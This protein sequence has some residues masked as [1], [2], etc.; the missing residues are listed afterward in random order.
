[1]RSTNASGSVADG[2]YAASWDT[3][4]YK[5]VPKLHV[6]ILSSSVWMS[7]AVLRLWLCMASLHPVSFAIFIECW[8]DVPVS[9]LYSQPNL[10]SHCT[11]CSWQISPEQ[12]QL[13]AQ[14]DA[15]SW[16]A[17]VCLLTYIERMMLIVGIRVLV[18]HKQYNKCMMHVWS[19][20]WEHC[21]CCSGCVLHTGDSTCQMEWSGCT[22]M[23]SACLIY[24]NFTIL[25]LDTLQQ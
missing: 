12:W 19:W 1:M 22:F 14:I 24:I 10:I 13:E 9:V 18:Y 20:S 3:H 16:N 5:V 7:T 15:N 6:Q 11:G 2:M 23:C 4:D 8:M 21:L 25:I 17:N